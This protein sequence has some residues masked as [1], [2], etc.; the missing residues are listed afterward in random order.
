MHHP[1]I[2]PFI[3]CQQANKRNKLTSQ[4]YPLTHQYQP[5]E[6]HPGAPPA[7]AAMAALAPPMAQRGPRPAGRTAPRSFHA[8]PRSVSCCSRANLPGRAQRSA[9]GFIG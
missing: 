3:K 4:F 7:M 9:V 5:L 2:D 6:F 1:L 8:A